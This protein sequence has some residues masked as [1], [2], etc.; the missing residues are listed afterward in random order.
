MI[1][2]EDRA[3]LKTCILLATGIRMGGMRAYNCI[4]SE[5]FAYWRWTDDS[6]V[7]G[8]CSLG[9]KPITEEK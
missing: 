6:K 5:C 1:T 7:K 4:A 8:Y 2:N 9:E 3:K